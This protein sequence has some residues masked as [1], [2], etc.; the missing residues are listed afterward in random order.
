MTR[1]KTASATPATKPGPPIELVTPGADA[2][3]GVLVDALRAAGTRLMQHRAR[4]IQRRE[5]ASM[6]D[7]ELRDLGLSRG[8]V[9]AVLDGVDVQPRRH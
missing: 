2:W 6:S 5:M 4:H 7:Y 1:L 9:A 8:Q 3:T